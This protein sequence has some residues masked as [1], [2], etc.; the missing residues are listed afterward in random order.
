MT[1]SQQTQN[2]LL[3]MIDDPQF[4]VRK[5][6]ALNLDPNLLYKMVN[7]NHFEIRIIVAKHICKNDIHLLKNDKDCTVRLIVAQRIDKKTALLMSAIDK[8]KSVRD[9]AWKNVMGLIEH[10]NE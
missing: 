5:Y 1:N 8:S 2:N 9:E 10:T 7:D 6:V 4:Y 3:D